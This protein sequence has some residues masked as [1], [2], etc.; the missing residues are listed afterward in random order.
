M[1]NTPSMYHHHPTTAA[2]T[3]DV[4]VTFLLSP[5]KEF[6]T[7]SL[8]NTLHPN[9]PTT[10]QLA[11]ALQTTGIQVT[12]SPSLSR[13]ITVNAADQ[14]DTSVVSSQRP[15]LSLI[16]PPADSSIVHE[17]ATSSGSVPLT[18]RRSRFGL[19]RKAS[20]SKS[21]SVDSAP[22][23]GGSPKET[24]E[25]RKSDGGQSSVGGGGGAAAAAASADEKTGEVYV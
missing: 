8:N 24:A 23:S 4:P 25:K 7:G 1:A 20:L 16:I 12:G 19:N 5:I 10:L 15:V 2:S 18:R 14:C 6:D 9:S 11:Q 21:T 17:V 3:T 22:S 13:I